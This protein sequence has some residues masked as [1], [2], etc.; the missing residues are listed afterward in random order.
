ME[1]YKRLFPAIFAN[2]K[3]AHGFAVRISGIRVDKGA[4]EIT[5]AN[6]HRWVAAKLREG[7]IDLDAT[8]RALNINSLPKSED[9]NSS[10]S[11]ELINP[12]EKIRTS[13]TNAI[14]SLDEEVQRL[15]IKGDL[16]RTNRLTLF[17]SGSPFSNLYRTLILLNN[18]LELSYSE[19]MSDKEVEK[20]KADLLKIYPTSH[21]EFANIKE[22]FI[23]I[24]TISTQ[25]LKIL[26]DLAML[27]PN[28][29][30]QVRGLQ[31]MLSSDVLYFR[32]RSSLI[33]LQKIID[34]H[35]A[36]DPNLT[37]IGN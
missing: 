36:C 3:V 12:L 14:S 20:L 35:G 31:F 33:L 26:E 29:K 9:L 19:M 28:T 17:Q 24:S 32:I 7:I 21:F 15:I 5:Q 16:N 37:P 34:A 8:P 23:E 2:I 30:L 25:E 1:F 13:I 18:Y 6:K 11:P 27:N 4:G 10:N 22:L